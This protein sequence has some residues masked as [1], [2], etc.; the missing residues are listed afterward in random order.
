MRIQKVRKLIHGHSASWNSRGRRCNYRNGLIRLDAT[1]PALDAE[2]RSSTRGMTHKAARCVCYR[3]SMTSMS[4]HRLFQDDLPA[5]SASRMRA[6][7][8]VTS[9][10]GSVVVLFGEGD[11]ALRRTV[12]VAHQKFPNGGGWSFSSVQRAAGA[13]ACS[14]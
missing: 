10:M 14:D 1:R 11:G 12:R 5:V 2:R 9:D 8:V 6:S 4:G 7:G 3:D 13:C